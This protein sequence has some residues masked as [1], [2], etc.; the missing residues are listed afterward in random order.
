MPGL[1]ISFPLVLLMLLLCSC[2]KAEIVEIIPDSE[3]PVISNTG[4][5]PAYSLAELTEASD[6]IFHGIVAEV[7][8]TNLY[9]GE[10][11]TLPYT[12]VM[13]KVLEAYKGDV[14]DEVLFKRDGG[15]T[16]THILKSSTFEMTEGM[17]AVFFM[18]EHGVG[19]GPYASWIVADDVVVLNWGVKDK[20]EPYGVELFETDIREHLV[21]ELFLDSTDRVRSCKLSDFA[22]VVKMLVKTE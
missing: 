13:L 15:K 5:F 6:Y 1:K 2:S 4:S 20:L 10:G 17:E 9:D 21:A 7:R 14:P 16:K 19:F 11:Y 3:L 22:D 12:P 8:E 18:N